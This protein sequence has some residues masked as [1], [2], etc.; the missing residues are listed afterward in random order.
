MA[1]NKT[2]LHA[3][4]ERE[5]FEQ[6]NPTNDPAKAVWLISLD[7][8]EEEMTVGQMVSVYVG[9]TQHTNHPIARTVFPAPRCIVEKTHRLATAEEIESYLAAEAVKKA[10]LDKA[11]RERKTQMNINM[12]S[13]P[14]N[15]ELM[16]LVTM[17]AEKML[18]EKAEKD[19]KPTAKK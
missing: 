1:L 11:E 12:N 6:L 17:M 4:K 5:V 3:R 15:D 9:H 14:Q 8:E 10:E 13:A 7:N 18:A 16:K 19:A 2:Q